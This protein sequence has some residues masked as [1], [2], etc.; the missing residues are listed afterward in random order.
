MLKYLIEVGQKRENEAIRRF[1]L[2]EVSREFFESLGL[3]FPSCWCILNINKKDLSDF[4]GD[5]DIIAGRLELNN[6]GKIKKWPPPTDYLIGV[7]VKC[8]Y[9]NLG[10]N[11]ISLNNIK[12]RHFSH[13]K[14]SKLRKQVQIL[15]EM[16]FDKVAL[17]DIIA[18]PPANGINGQ[19]WLTAAIISTKSI[20]VFSPVLQE[21]LPPDSPAGHWVWSIGSVSGGDETKRGASLL[22]RLKEAKINPLLGDA[23]IQS[24]RQ[25]MEGKLKTILAELRPKHLPAIFPSQ[26]EH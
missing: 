20:E 1:L 7:E 13:R 17:L 15:L 12:S 4:V 6:S 9:V 22:S 2:N 5:I 8:A 16:G 10:A 3:P 19:A 21:R 23:K 26:K 11:Q 24:H 25:R 18:N 14:V